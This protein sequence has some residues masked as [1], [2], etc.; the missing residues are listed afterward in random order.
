VCAKGPVAFTSLFVPECVTSDVMH[1]VYY[2]PIH[3]D[4]KCLL[5]NK[6][7]IELFDEVIATTLWPSELKNRK[8]RP[9]SEINLYK[10]SEWK[11]LILY[12]TVPVLSKFLLDSKNI[13]EILKKQCK[14]I[15]HGVSA[16]L[17]LM[18]DVSYTSQSIL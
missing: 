15:L 18:K 16:L 8:L 5:K 17:L 9:I 6:V 2:G 4:L 11:T 13:S 14:N 12:I 3:D 10:A 1:T 7:L